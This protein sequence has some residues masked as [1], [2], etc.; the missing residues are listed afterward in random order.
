MSILNILFH[1]GAIGKSLQ[2]VETLA[3]DIVHGKNI[4]ADAQKVLGDLGDLI[5][6]GMISIPGVEKSAAIAEISKVINR[7]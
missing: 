5:D 6:S 2:D 3:C 7:V 4:S 1:A